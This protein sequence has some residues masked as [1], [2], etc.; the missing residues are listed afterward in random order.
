MANNL[1]IMFGWEGSRYREGILLFEI[2]TLSESET[3]PTQSALSD[4][5]MLLCG[6]VRITVTNS[7]IGTKTELNGMLRLTKNEIERI[8]I[9]I[10]ND[11]QF[12]VQYY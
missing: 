6:E 8:L 2:N 12:L 5:A 3:F 10:V 4:L 9:S 11:I 1:K 7:E